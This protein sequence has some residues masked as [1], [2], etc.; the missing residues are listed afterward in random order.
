MDYLTEDALDLV[1]SCVAKIANLNGESTEFIQSS[2][3]PEFNKFRKQKGQ[4]SV[5]GS[6]LCPAYEWWLRRCDS[7][8]FKKAAIRIASL[9]SSSANIERTFATLNI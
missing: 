5:P 6:E 7:G 4:Y 8:G 2:I 9:T 3:V 1:L